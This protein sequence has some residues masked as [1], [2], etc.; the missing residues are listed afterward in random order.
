[1]DD[2][3]VFAQYNR[4]PQLS[5]GV[6]DNAKS[7]Y[8]AENS[9]QKALGMLGGAAKGDYGRGA[10]PMIGGN[11][12][13]IGQ[14]VGSLWK[15]GAGSTGSQPG[16]SDAAETGWSSQEDLDAANAT[17]K[18]MMSASA[19]TSADASGMGIGDMA[20]MAMAFI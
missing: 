3:S 8:G 18:S 5:F 13:Q 14:A 10:A 20:S 15:P 19:G 6:Q 11:S 1:M 12:Y 2:E 17:A 9:Y 4:G 7:K 16:A